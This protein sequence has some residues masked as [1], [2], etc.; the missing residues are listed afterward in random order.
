MYVSLLNYL[1][2]SF[3][4]VL[5]P[6]QTISLE[7]PYPQTLSLQSRYDYQKQT[8]FLSSVVPNEI[9]ISQSY[10]PHVALSLPPL[11]PSLFFP[12]SLSLFW[13]FSLVPRKSRVHSLICIAR[14]F[15][16][17]VPAVTKIP[18]F[19]VGQLCRCFCCIKRATGWTKWPRGTVGHQILWRGTVTWNQISHFLLVL[20]LVLSNFMN[21][22]DKK[23]PTII[24]RVLPRSAEI[25]RWYGA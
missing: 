22:P 10:T 2:L 19:N 6:T 25:F 5:T 17:C 9:S 14:F 8:N 4:K 13:E 16:L 12:L 23:W 3:S 15:N 21:L 18:L 20:Q 1:S 11:S 24:V 7:Y